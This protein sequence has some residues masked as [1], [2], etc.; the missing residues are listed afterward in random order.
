MSREVTLSSEISRAAI[1]DV[2][3]MLI[4]AS[5]TVTPT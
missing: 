1:A 4:M 3:P 5:I 2:G